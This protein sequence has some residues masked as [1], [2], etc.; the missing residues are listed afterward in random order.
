MWQ[1]LET[2]QRFIDQLLRGEVTERT[3]EDIGATAALTAAE[4]KAL[5]TGR[6]EIL[7]VVRLDTEIRR[8]SALEAHHADNTRHLA[9]NAQGSE[10]QVVALA[11]DIEEWRADLATVRAA[12]EQA[13]SRAPALEISGTTFGGDGY[14]KPAGQA[15]AALMTHAQAAASASRDT[16]LVGRAGSYAGLDIRVGVRQR[17]AERRVVYEPQLWLRGRRSYEVNGSLDKPETLIASLEAQ[18]HPSHIEASI[19]NAERRREEERRR[20]ADLRRELAK[21]FEHEAALA[22]L[23][24]RRDALVNELQLRDDGD[25]I[26]V[27]AETELKRL[28]SP[29]LATGRDAAIER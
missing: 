9:W 15:L 8:L 11:R 12:R 17:V 23:R 19:A 6:P 1:T 18:A 25:V 20:I 29:V 21:P 4:C 10:Q 24:E 22:Q 26:A 5:A 7:E 28:P 14:R 3:V 16:E 2:K 27:E 13:G